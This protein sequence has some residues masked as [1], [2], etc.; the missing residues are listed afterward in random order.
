MNAKG[1]LITVAVLGG[2]YAIWK[3]AKDAQDK[4]EAAKKGIIDGSEKLSKATFAVADPYNL[5]D[6]AAEKAGY[7]SALSDMS[8]KDALRTLWYDTKNKLNPF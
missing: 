8:A 3:I 6:K 4:V 7:F 5:T 2:I 1:L